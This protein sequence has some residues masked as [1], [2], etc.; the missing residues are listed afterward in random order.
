MTPVVPC[1]LLHAASA[2]PPLPCRQRGDLSR[3]D[4]S[5]W[6]RSIAS[7]LVSSDTLA[8]A[9]GSRRPRRGGGGEPPAGSARHSLT[10]A[11]PSSFSRTRTATLR[12]AKGCLTASSNR[13]ALLHARFEGCARTPRS[14]TTRTHTQ[15]RR[16]R[17]PSGPA[18][19]HFPAR[20][21]VFGLCRPARACGGACGRTSFV[22]MCMA[23]GGVDCRAESGLTG[24]C[25]QREPRYAL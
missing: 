10:C 17:P 4:L 2:M 14:H 15:P 18:T 12:G 20:R 8:L 25:R 5:R 23:S 1:R 6:P 16:C 13:R 9:P 24:R 21:A 22:R 19:R 3:W 11:R 7:P